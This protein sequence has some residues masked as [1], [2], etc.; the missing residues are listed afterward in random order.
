MR[1]GVEGGISYVEVN[2]V[3]LLPSDEYLV[4][5]PTSMNPFEGCGRGWRESRG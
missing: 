3:E 1:G 2:E 5:A 4:G